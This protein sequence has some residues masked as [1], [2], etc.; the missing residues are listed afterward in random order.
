[1]EMKMIYS[2]SVVITYNSLDNLDEKINFIVS[3]L[4]NC[5]EQLQKEVAR[6]HLNASS[7]DLR[8]KFA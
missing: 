2:I 8:Y 6:K 1:M 4:S 7:D 5:K 3:M